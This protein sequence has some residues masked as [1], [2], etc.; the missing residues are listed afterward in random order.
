MMNQNTMNQNMMNQNAPITQPRRTKHKSNVAKPNFIPKAP[1]NLMMKVVPQIGKELTE[2]YKAQGVALD[3]IRK[4]VKIEKYVVYHDRKGD[5]WTWLPT[6]LP[7][8]Q[9][10]ENRGIKKLGQWHPNPQ[11]K[12]DPVFEKIESE[13]RDARNKHKAEMDKIKL[14]PQYVEYDKRKKEERLAWHNAPNMNQ[15]YQ[16]YGQQQQQQQYNPQNIQQLPSGVQ[17]V[18]MNTTPTPPPTT[19]NTTQPMQN[20][21]QP[22]YTPPPTYKPTNTGGWGTGLY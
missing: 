7:I 20:T 11:G 14:T 22:N 13:I 9:K 10:P 15:Q 6:T 3:T 21:T 16:Y 4:R 2:K 17:P 18:T 8:D 5:V 19:V 12:K 1:T